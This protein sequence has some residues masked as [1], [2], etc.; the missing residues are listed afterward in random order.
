M[1]ITHFPYLLDKQEVIIKLNKKTYQG[2]KE[3]DSETRLLQKWD[4]PQ[5]WEQLHNEEGPNEIRIQNDICTKWNITKSKFCCIVHS[6]N[7]VLTI[8][9]NDTPFSINDMMI[10]EN[11]TAL[12]W[13]LWSPTQAYNAPRPSALLENCNVCA[14]SKQCAMETSL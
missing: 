13:T 9:I 12:L 3:L 10:F 8:F 6:I 5:D 7:F 1:W 2:N 4:D 11:P 14:N